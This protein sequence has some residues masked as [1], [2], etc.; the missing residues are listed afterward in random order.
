MV[1]AMCKLIRWVCLTLAVLSCRPALFETPP[2]SARPYGSGGTAQRPVEEPEPP[3]EPVINLYASAYCFPDSVDW[4]AGAP[5]SGSLLLLKNGAELLRLPTE[6]KLEPDRHRIVKGK[7]WT[8]RCENGQMI[9]SCNGQ[10]RFRFA[11]EEVFNGF[12][13]DDDR[14][15]TL[16]QRPGGGVTFRVNGQERFSS[17]NG[18]LLNGPEEAHWEGGAFCVDT[19]GIYYAYGVPIRKQNQVTWEY[20][21]MNGERTEKTVPLGEGCQMYDIR[22]WNG[23][24]YRVENRYGALYMVKGENNLFVSLQSGEAPHYCKLVPAGDR[25]LLKGYS[26]RPAFTYWFREPDDLVLAVTGKP[27]VSELVMDGE[28]HGYLQENAAG[29]ILGVYW[30]KDL[31][32]RSDGRHTL[33][34]SRCVQLKKQTFGVALTAATGR[35]HMLIRQTDTLTIRFNGYF[36]SVQID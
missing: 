31:V 6:G 18:L 5:S 17:G 21:V 19:G 7:L 29:N 10:E 22:V 23:T 20:R 28:H 30:D 11:G 8:D 9:V 1:N 32:F 14:V 13:V 12:W 15:Y 34:S 24:V 2:R 35:R 25:M 33:T 4:R 26:Y 27:V 3:A 16:G 36:T